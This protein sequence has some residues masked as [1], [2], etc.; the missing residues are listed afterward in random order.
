M[1]SARA[2]PNVQLNLIGDIV[3]CDGVGE[4]VILPHLWNFDL[5]AVGDVIVLRTTGTGLAD[6]KNGDD[7]CA[8]TA[9]LALNHGL[10]TVQAVSE[11]SRQISHLRAG[12]EEEG[13]S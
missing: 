5:L 3:A 11:T 12:A 9:V 10:A 7:T 6:D 8:M 4:L 13:Q 1:P 2:Q